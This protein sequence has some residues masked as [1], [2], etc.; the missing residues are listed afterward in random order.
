MMDPSRKKIGQGFSLVE[1]VVILFIMSLGLVGILSL[2]VQNIQSQNY[3]K[4]NLVAYQ[5][6]QEGVELIRKVRDTNWREGLAYDDKLVSGQYTMDYQDSTPQAY[7]PAAPES[8]RLRQDYSNF[9]THQ[10]AAT[11]TPFSRIITIQTLDDHSFQ[12][13]ASVRWADHGRNYS[14]DLDTVLYNWR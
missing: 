9:Y 10:L 5:L 13:E 1:V 11:T 7:N 14:Y 4:N 6:A 8:A 12:V 3:N 2:I